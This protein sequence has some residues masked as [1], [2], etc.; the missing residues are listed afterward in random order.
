MVRPIG[1]ENIRKRQAEGIE[2]ARKMGKHLGRPK[3][4]LPEN[5]DEILEAWKSREITARYAMEQL[6]MGSSAFYN[7]VKERGIQKVEFFKE[8][9]RNQ[10]TLN[11]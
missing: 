4:E 1:T 7:L 9:E 8:K 5:A 6:G 3:L 11:T 10:A 2:A